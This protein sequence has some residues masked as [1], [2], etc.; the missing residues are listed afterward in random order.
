M[1]RPALSSEKAL[2]ND[3]AVTVK[4]NTKNVSTSLKMDSFPLRP[5]AWV[6]KRDVTTGRP[7]RRAL[8][9]HSVEV[10]R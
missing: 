6:D 10:V 5:P 3:K 1:K 8:T 7:I 2:L 9:L 4:T